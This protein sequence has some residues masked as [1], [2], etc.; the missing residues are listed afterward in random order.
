[1]PLQILLM[2]LG[3]ALLIKGGDWL[4]S[5]SSALAR[6]WGVSDLLVGLTIVSFGTSAPEMVVSILASVQ[7][8]ADISVG[9]ILGSNIIN[10]LLILG[11]TSIIYPLFA[12]RGTIWNE[13][14]FMMLASVV[15]A[16]QVNDRLLDGTNYSGLTR[17]DGLI[18]LMFFCI[19]IYYLLNVFRDGDSQEA[20]V[21][22]PDADALQDNPVAP[23][24][25]S[26]AVF[27]ILLGL[28]FLVLGGH[29][30]VQSAIFLAS[31]LGMS[32]RVI[33]ITVVAIGTS[34]PELV[35]SIVAAFKKNAEIAMGNIVGSNIFNLLLVLGVSSTIT[36]LAFESG[37]NF[38]V[39]MMVASSFLL[40]LFML[41]G[42]PRHQL[43]R[44]EGA[45]MVILYFAYIGYSV[46]KG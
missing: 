8:N 7:N 18:L 25:S 43:Q 4:V 29:W 15:V 31:E 10:I 33:G 2:I 35:T 27:W 46:W 30:V 3:F 23:Q 6:R 14:P 9:N 39:A 11:L 40:F 45:F 19:F 17:S 32:E 38:D 42:K 24:S 20:G 28:A 36:P 16:V 44:L 21:T 1:M 5:A 12:T 37:A 41:V 13:I 22:L 34:L 26:A